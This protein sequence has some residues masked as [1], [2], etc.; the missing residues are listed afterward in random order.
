ME[1]EQSQMARQLVLLQQ[2]LQAL[3]ASAPERPPVL[4]RLQPTQ[5]MR[6]V[7]LLQ[8]TVPAALVPISAPALRDPPRKEHL[9]TSLCPLLRPTRLRCGNHTSGR[10]LWKR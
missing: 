1:T 10:T 3:A 6:K 4:R 2:E 9:S 7:K 5:R 8:A